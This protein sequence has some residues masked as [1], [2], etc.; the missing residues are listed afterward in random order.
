MVK[1]RFD[2][3][4]IFR[5]ARLALS[6][7]RLWIQAV[8]LF[9]GYLG[10]LIFTYIAILTTGAQFKA[11]WLRYGLL[12]H[13]GMYQLSW[14]GY[15]LFG[16]GLLIFILFWMATSTAV[17]RAVY[18]HLKGFSFYTWKDTF[19]FSLSKVGSII[20][21]P[22][23][24]GAIAFFTG[25]G[26]V[27]I[28]L[29]GKIAFIGELGVS[30]FTPVW[31]LA[32]VFIVFIILGFGVSLLL[33]PSILA[34]TDDDA[35]EGIFQSFSTTYSQPWRL[36]IYEIL[37]FAVSV[38]GFLLMSL[39]FK[40]AWKLMN[41]ILIWGMGEKF[42]DLS[43]KA[44]YLL[45]NWTYPA[46]LWSKSILGDYTSYFFFTRTFISIEISAV[47]N[48]SS[49]IMAIFLVFIGG[50]LISYPIAIFN[51]GNS[52]IFLI[53]KKKKDDEN[54]LERKDREEEEDEVDLEDA[55]ESDKKIQPSKD[56]KQKD[57]K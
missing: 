29:L 53:L 48:I 6:L 17:A 16:L 37:L 20:A 23:S 45:Q 38:A 44:S 11:V 46:I 13:I 41:M 49:W 36:V 10:Y 30:L 54:L 34:T 7:Q 8:G 22:L 40:Q 3:R 1:L 5:A 43:Y 42:V 47:L 35:F 9:F 25:L 39:F 18:M 26:G 15:V 31:F 2:F 32:S 56:S 55:G 51:S 12:P 27:I 57:K 50:Y 33:T 21:T 24:I 19:K 28:G 4:D 14:Y 52:I